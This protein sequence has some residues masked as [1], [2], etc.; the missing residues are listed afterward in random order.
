MKTSGDQLSFSS[1]LRRDHFYFPYL[2]VVL[3]IL[4]I[5]II[6]YIVFKGQRNND[7]KN[8]T[9]SPIPH[10][11]NTLSPFTTD[12]TISHRI[13][14]SFLLEEELIKKQLEFYENNFGVEKV[15]C[16]YFSATQRESMLQSIPSIEDKNEVLDRI[17]DI[18]SS[19]NPHYEVVRS[20]IFGLWYVYE[21]G[22]WYVRFT[23]YLPNS[24]FRDKNMW[25][26]H[27]TVWVEKSLTTTSTNIKNSK[28]Q[29]YEYPFYNWSALY[30]RKRHHPAIHSL[31]VR[32]LSLLSKPETCQGKEWP[33]PTKLSDPHYK[34]FFILFTPIQRISVGHSNMNLNNWS[35]IL[36]PFRWLNQRVPNPC[37][38]LSIVYEYANKIHQEPVLLPT[39]TQTIP[40][41]IFLTWKDNNLPSNVLDNWKVLNPSYNVHLYTDDDCYEFL[42]QTF[43]KEYADYFREIPFG[44][45]KADWWRICILYTKGGV[46]VDA[47]VEPIGVPF[48]SI[49]H[50]CT[51][52]TCIGNTN[53]HV[54]QAILAFPAN[55]PILEECITLLYDKRPMVQNYIQQKR[56]D[57]SFYG[58]LSGTSDMYH[59]ILRFFNQ[60]KIYGDSYY[61]VPKTSKMPSPY[62]LKLAQEGCGED[63]STCTS[64]FNTVPLFK[65]RYANYVSEW[66]VHDHA[67]GKFL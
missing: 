30:C 6:V 66:M 37:Y 10:N 48:D 9:E 36:F 22:G 43:S 13:V 67:P 33:S 29:E 16:I 41:Q 17:F 55:D 7:G 50:D 52:F 39:R 12:N 51:S 60:N 49:L 63:Y 14:C 32:S 24:L 59:S 15:D 27:P 58:T 47:D 26:H 62:I 25:R 21:Y 54:F 1:P 64:F 2:F 42:L 20:W 28:N 35:S 40:R 57:F 38:H 5:I 23:E 46:Y 11:T 65:S 4:I 8:K 18:Y 56:N 44:P 61:I 19:I 45:I 3:M 34:L 31:L 53:D